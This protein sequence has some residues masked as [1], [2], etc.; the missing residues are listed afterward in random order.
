MAFFHFVGNLQRNGALQSGRFDFFQISIWD[1]VTGEVIY[2][3]GILYDE[4][5][6]VLLGGIRVKE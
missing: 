3:N 4:G 1:D 6:L 2:D 5:D